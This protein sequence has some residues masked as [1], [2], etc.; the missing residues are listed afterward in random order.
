MSI[1]PTLVRSRANPSIIAALMS[2]SLDDNQ[3]AVK[4]SCSGFD[5]E[6][7]VGC[8]FNYHSDRWAMCPNDDFEAQLHFLEFL[9]THATVVEV[10]RV[11]V[12]L[13]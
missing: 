6:A 1:L 7:P 5:G 12:H 4:I 9:I 8:V 10:V 13:H 11:P 3:P 2:D